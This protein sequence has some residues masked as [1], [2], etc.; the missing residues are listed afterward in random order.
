MQVHT[1]GRRVVSSGVTAKG[2]FGI[3]QNSQAHIMTILRDTLYSDKILAVL[4][5]YSS[6]A[7]DAHRMVGKN[8][9]PIRITLPETETPTLVIRDF[10]PGMSPDEVFNI[11]TQY[12]ESTKRGTDDA[13]GMMGIG[14]LLAGQPIVTPDGMKPIEE[15]QV[16]DL[17]LT[18]MGRFRRVTKLMSRPYKGKAFKVW[19]SQ[20]PEPLILTEEHPFLV[21][22]AKGSAQWLLPGDIQTGYRS[23][24]KGIKAWKSY[25]MLPATIENTETEIQAS[26]YLDASYMAEGGNL[27]KTTPF[28]HVVFG[29]VCPKD[30]VTSWDFPETLILDEELGWLLGLF[31][32]EGS[33]TSKQVTISLNINETELAD[34]FIQGM[35]NRFGIPFKAYP[36]PDRTLLELVSHHTALACFLG[37]LCGRG[38]ENK[39]VPACIMQGTPEVRKGFLRG[40]LDGDGSSTQPRFVFGV[41]S[42]K[43]AWGV[44]TLMA[45]TGDKWGTVGH[46]PQYNRWGVNYNRGTSFAYSFRQGNYLQRPITKTESFDLDSEVFNFSV[47][48]DESYVSNFILHNCKSAFSYSDSFTVTSWNGGMKRI[49]VAVLDASNIGEI[50]CLDETPCDPEET[51][52]EIQ[53]PVQI[54]DMHEFRSKALNLFRY[55]E[56]QPDINI[57]LPTIKRDARANGFVSSDMTEW[58]AIMGCIPYRLNLAQVS[59]ELEEEGLWKPLQKIKGGLRFGIGEVHISASREELKYTDYTKKAIIAKF[60]AMIDEHI[61]EALR[62]IKDAN[63]SDWEKRVKSNFMAHVIGFK[64]PKGFTE[65]SKQSVDLWG[66]MIPTSLLPKNHALPR[67]ALPTQAVL[68]NEDEDLDSRPVDSTTYADVPVSAADPMVRMP[69]PRTFNL[70][71]GHRDD[72]AVHC[73]QV[74]QGGNTRF[75][76]KDDPRPM[77]GFAFNSYDVVVCP[78]PGVSLDAVGA[79]LKEYITL[80]KIAG[81]PIELLSKTGLSWCK[82]WESKEEIKIKRDKNPKYWTKAFKLKPSIQNYNSHHSM[83][84][85]PAKW[86]ASDADVYVLLESFEPKSFGSGSNF[87]SAL[88]EDKLLADWLNLPFPEV[89]GYKDTMTSPANMKKI[90]GTEYRA[91]RIK[92]FTDAIAASPEI[93]AMIEMMS[94]SLVRNEFCVSGYYANLMIQTVDEMTKV[95]GADHTFVSAMG[96]LVKANAEVMKNRI[97]IGFVERIIQIINPESEAK[98]VMGALTVAYP[99]LFKMTDVFHMMNSGMLSSWIAYIQVCDDAAAY[100][101]ADALADNILAP[102]IGNIVSDICRSCGLPDRRAA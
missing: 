6:N 23:D 50:Q 9:L 15:I 53:V 63:L 36:R 22:N 38:S 78:T 82:P 56:P 58:M 62:D 100:R 95:L 84:W 28:N 41:S 43:L 31:A 54:H 4:R 89:Y 13:V 68:V 42:P 67:V 52:I 77:K 90:K 34:R 49:Y 21:G 81:V 85:E 48:E 14:C 30:R 29:T 91:W 24:K 71:N 92:F 69:A 76:I 26:D 65:W 60:S 72:Y 45:V 79:E 47:E 74:T 64:L 7:W 37:N 99:L 10:G 33:A 83:N 16:G 35:K 96:K 93:Q 97:G 44:R 61:E 3:S 86:E 17:V 94:W 2:T 46:M 101:A 18:H 80:A 40:V 66:Y 88:K 27:T 70:F 57:S 8:D 59:R 39:H 73:I 55:F 5:E 51:G 32:A 1:D 87:Y 25:A 102:G 75:V 19:V 20:A 12:G 11:Y 98:K